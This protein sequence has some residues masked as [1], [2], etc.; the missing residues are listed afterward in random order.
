M[1]IAPKYPKDVILGPPPLIPG[2]GSTVNP[3]VYD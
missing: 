3:D 2:F 1:E